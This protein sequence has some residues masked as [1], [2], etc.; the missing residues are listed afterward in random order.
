MR[1]ICICMILYWFIYTSHQAVLNLVMF[2]G[3]RSPFLD[4]YTCFCMLLHKNRQF[5]ASGA[6]ASGRHWVLF[7]L[8]VVQSEAASD[9]LHRCRSLFQKLI[10]TSSGWWFRFRR[11][12]FL[13]LTSGN[14]SNVSN[15]FSDGL[16]QPPTSLQIFL[17]CVKNN[18]MWFELQKKPVAAFQFGRF[19]EHEFLVLF[20]PQKTCWWWLVSSSPKYCMSF[21][22]NIYMYMYI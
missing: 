14:L 5:H 9:Y 18:K 22:K 12:F 1:A 6:F 2:C 3:N 13:S 19:W 17:C 4:F 11:F 15:I 7:G 21:W 8:L 10:P 20:L 16:V